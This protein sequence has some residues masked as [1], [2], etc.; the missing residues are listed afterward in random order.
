[1]TQTNKPQTLLLFLFI[2]LYV[3]CSFSQAYIR[4]NE[5]GDSCY[6]QGNY[7]AALL[8][9][10]KSLLINPSYIEALSS[11]G[12]AYS[13]LEKNKAAI[14]DFTKVIQSKGTLL[15]RVHAY[16]KRANC[17]LRE[18]EFELAIKDF[19]SYLDWTENSDS[20]YNRAYAYY[21]INDYEHAIADYSMIL[22]SKESDAYKV[23]VY[24]SRAISYYQIDSTDDAM[25]DIK[26]GLSINQ[27]KPKFYGLKWHIHFD[28]G[29]LVNAWNDLKDLKSADS[30]YEYIDELTGQSYYEEGKNELAIEAFNRQL[31]KLPENTYSYWCRGRAYMEMKEYAKAVKDFDKYVAENPTSDAYNNKGWSHLFLKNYKEA[32]S[33]LNKSIALDKDNNDAYDS[34]GCA[35]Y[36]LGDYAGAILDFNRAIK[37]NPEYANSY[38]H[39]AKCYIKLKNK[40]KVCSDL[41]TALKLKDYTVFAGEKSC[42]ELLTEHCSR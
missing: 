42:K 40:Q 30:T 2:Q 10:N 33:D 23:D 32:L 19:T 36:F 17:Y 29:D 37:V 16:N 26:K 35:K 28:D 15:T 18:K 9:F 14:R 31:A 11:R 4:Y 8:Y 38:F 24:Y 22:D 21:T 27:Y 12:Y 13:A 7:E 41:K 34:R 25:N 5:Q 1:M 39:R 6:T 3:S 20:R